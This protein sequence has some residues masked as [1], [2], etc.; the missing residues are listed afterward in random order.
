ML[1]IRGIAQVAGQR[2]LVPAAQCRTV[3]GLRL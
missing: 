2:N 3:D 1:G